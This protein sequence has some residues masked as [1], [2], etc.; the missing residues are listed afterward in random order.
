MKKLLFAGMLLSCTIAQGMDSGAIEDIRHLFKVDF[1]TKQILR[2]MDTLT[3]EALKFFKQHGIPHNLFDNLVVH[4]MYEDALA[5][6]L[7]EKSL[8]EL[9]KYQELLQKAVGPV[10]LAADKLVVSFK[11]L[12]NKGI[13]EKT[14]QST[15]KDTALLFLPSKFKIEFVRRRIPKRRSAVSK[16]RSPLS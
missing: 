1:K 10:E 7:N 11:K 13:T 8:Q 6:Q 12:I 9:Q 5:F 14:K 3:P 4:N 16:S 15:L 2:I